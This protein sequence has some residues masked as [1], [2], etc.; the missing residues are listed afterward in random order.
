M[1]GAAALSGF[2]QQTFV[3]IR[4]S[5]TRPGV[6]E[7]DR[8]PIPDGITAEPPPELVPATGKKWWQAPILIFQRILMPRSPYP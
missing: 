8:L 7:H 6:F 3:S 2:A 4:G 1:H 5:E